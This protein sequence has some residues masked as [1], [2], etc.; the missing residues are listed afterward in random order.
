MFMADLQTAAY[1]ALQLAGEAEL[2]VSAPPVADAARLQGFDDNLASLQSRIIKDPEFFS[3]LGV[4]DFLMLDR[5]NVLRSQAQRV[6][7]EPDRSGLSGYFEDAVGMMEWLAD[8]PG[9]KEISF[10]LGTLQ[11]TLRES[12]V[13]LPGSRPERP[14]APP[15]RARPRPVKVFVAAGKD[16]WAAAGELA[17]QLG[18]YTLGEDQVK[19]LQSWEVGELSRYPLVT[20]WSR[21]K[22]CG[23]GAL[24]LVGDEA[25]VDEK[26][27]TAGKPV[28][29]RRRLSADVEFQLGLMVGFFGV[30]RTFMVLPKSQDQQPDLATLLDGLTYAYYDPADVGGN[31]A[32]GLVCT[33]IMQ[34]IRAHEKKLTA[35]QEKS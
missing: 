21:I 7:A 20:A 22:G 15:P 35:A 27:A 2:A 4:P 8:Q 23:Y 9:V 14:G 31:G 24:V 10:F 6:I 3:S 1:E 16:G 34:A 28:T 12:P 32:M 18:A 13:S 5:L 30:E 33:Q 11:L 29:A 25:T 26:R 17:V 19:V